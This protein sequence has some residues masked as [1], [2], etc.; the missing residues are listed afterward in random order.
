VRL[1]VKKMELE[2]RRTKTSNCC[3]RCKHRYIRQISQCRLQDAYLQPVPTLC[4][5]SYLY[6]KVRKCY[7]ASAS[8]V[9]RAEAPAEAARVR[10]VFLC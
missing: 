7:F 10:V 6:H 1:T 3:N 4:F 9:C 5:N 8:T 2:S